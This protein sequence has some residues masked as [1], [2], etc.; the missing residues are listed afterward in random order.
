[1]A[2][3]CWVDDGHRNLATIPIGDVLGSGDFPNCEPLLDAFQIVL[4]PV[5]HK[6]GFAV[7]G[8]D[9]IFQSIQFAAMQ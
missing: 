4:E 6:N 3:R 8:L 7:C 5:G 2:S 1:M 9:Q